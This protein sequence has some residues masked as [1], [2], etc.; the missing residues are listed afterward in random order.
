MEH[1]VNEAVSVWRAIPVGRI[2]MITWEKGA[3]RMDE[4]LS[5]IHI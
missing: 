4:D 1:S 5:L 2:V 3:L